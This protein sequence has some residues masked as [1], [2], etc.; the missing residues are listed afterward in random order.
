MAHDGSGHDHVS[1]AH[2]IDIEFHLGKVEGL[3]LALGAT[4]DSL[5]SVTDQKQR[6]RLCGAGQEV[7][8]VLNEA[9]AEVNAAIAKSYR[10]RRAAA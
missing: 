9:I 5:A 1:F 6:M 7:S 8:A 2:I 3:A 4:L 10:E